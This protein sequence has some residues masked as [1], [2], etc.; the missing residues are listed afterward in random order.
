MLC[1]QGGDGDFMYMIVSYLHCLKISL[2]AYLRGL[3]S[4]N[5]FFFQQ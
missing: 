5:L 2:M 3:E 1:M 4:S